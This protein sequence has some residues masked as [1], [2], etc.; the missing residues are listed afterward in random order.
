MAFD[1][2]LIL[3]TIWPPKLFI[4]LAL[5]L[6]LYHVTIYLMIFRIEIF[7]RCLFSPKLFGFFT[8]A[9]QN[10]ISFCLT[11]TCCRLWNFCIRLPS[12]T[13]TIIEFRI[14][15]KIFKNNK[16]HLTC[17]LIFFLLSHYSLLVKQELFARI[18]LA[19]KGHLFH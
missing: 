2:I 13:I 19:S 5:S 17:P 8:T 11:A 18:H 15:V 4:L 9:K 7:A 10:D 3:A 12:Q 14:F 16:F 1:I 6:P